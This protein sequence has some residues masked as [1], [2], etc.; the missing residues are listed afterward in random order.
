M[1]ELLF[2]NE[3]IAAMP[4]YL[5]GVSINVYSV[6][7]L[8]YYIMNNTF[9]L[10]RSFMSEELCNWIENQALLPKLANRLRMII[11]TNGR[12]SV[13]V[14]EILN[15]TGYCTLQEIKQI[16]D[17]LRKLEEKSEFECI[18]LR[19]D[20]LMENEKYLSSIFEYNKLLNSEEA[21]TADS[22][23]CGNIYN[24]LA[25]AYASLFLFETAADLYRKAYSLNHNR[26]SLWSC[27][28]SYK[29]MNDE[30]HFKKIAAKY[31][32]DDK[33]LSSLENV[34]AGFFTGSDNSRIEDNM[35]QLK[36]LRTTDKTACNKQISDIILKYKEEY[37]SYVI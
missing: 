3:S 9:L 5:E 7:E 14:E 1:G 37:R 22:V 26:K 2:C 30:N 12:L 8:D 10:E 15:S 17:L 18:K 19:A 24:N 20:Q 28:Y 21:K 16:H 29:C 4:F 11:S 35:D 36:K 31:N 33:E 23:I 13:F 32:V 6:E 34:L 25:T 27:L